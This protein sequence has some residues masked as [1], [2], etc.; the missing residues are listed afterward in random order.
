[1]PLSFLH[2]SQIAEQN[3]YHRRHEGIDVDQQDTHG[4]RVNQSM[5]M[6]ASGSG[7]ETLQ[8]VSAL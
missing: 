6:V 3:R 5:V 2:R 7:S 4:A 1:M 8:T